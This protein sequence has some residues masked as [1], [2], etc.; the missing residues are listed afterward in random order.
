MAM[1][2][3]KYPITMPT[4]D[5]FWRVEISY[6]T[7]TSSGNISLAEI[8]DEDEAAAY[9]RAIKAD[10]NLALGHVGRPGARITE[11]KLLRFQQA[12]ITEDVTPAEVKA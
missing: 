12:M 6:E 5:P 11:V 9:Y 3:L 2:H 1:R 7:R 8:T 10:D 4:D